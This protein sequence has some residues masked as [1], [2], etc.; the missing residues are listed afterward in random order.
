MLGFGPLGAY[1]LGSAGP[2]AIQLNR[3]HPTLV[4]SGLIIPES[5]SSEG[6]LVRST[7]SVW[8][9]VAKL[10]AKDWSRAMEL[11]PRQWEE[12]VAGAYERAGYKVILTP[13]SGDFGRDIIASTAGIGSVRI[14]GSV[15]AYKAGHLV[16]ADAVRSLIGVI[17]GDRQASKGIITT[18]SDFAPRI[19]DDPSIAPMLPTRLELMNGAGL[20]AWLSD[21]ADNGPSAQRRAD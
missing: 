12:M 1:P 20:Q 13:S 8:L 17:A 10:F 18:T 14:L 21:L 4:L 11:S 9:E 3:L 15:K 6:L 5:Q 7:S 19:K 16:D 2:S